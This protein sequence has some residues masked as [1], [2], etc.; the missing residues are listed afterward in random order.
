[1]PISCEL[2]LELVDAHAR[3]GRIAKGLVMVCLMAGWLDGAYR[4]ILSDDLLQILVFTGIGV[5]AAM[6][7]AFAVAM[8]GAR[9][10]A[11]IHIGW[12]KSPAN[13]KASGAELD[14]LF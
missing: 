10:L 1:M 3:K 2:Y 7:G 5:L 12:A 8:P 6:I 11:R 9:R 13:A 4:W 14:H